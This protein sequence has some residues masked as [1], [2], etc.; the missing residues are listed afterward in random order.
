LV[1]ASPEFHLELWRTSTTH[2]TLPAGG[3]GFLG[4]AKHV[5]AQ[6]VFGAEVTLVGR[7]FAVGINLFLESLQEGLAGWP[8]S[9]ASVD[10][11]APRDFGGD[12]PVDVLRRDV[13]LPPL[14]VTFCVC[15]SVCL[16]G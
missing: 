15:L 12:L 9:G 11:A 8:G 14:G 16:N 10:C 13:A 7:Q 6:S 4:E 5:G 2:L 3:Y 1:P